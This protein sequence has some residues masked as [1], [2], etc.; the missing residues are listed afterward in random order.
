MEYKIQLEE[1]LK[2][3]YTFVSDIKPSDWTEQNMIMQKPF[4]GVFK[5]SKTPYAVEIINRISNDDSAHTVALMKGAQ[6]GM[7]AGVIIP[8][9]CWIIKNNPGN[10]YLSVGA[11]DLIEKAMEKL[12]LAI[13]CT[14]LRTLIKPQT[15]RA[16]NNKTGDTNSK[17]EFPNGYVSIGSANNHKNLRQVDLQFVFLDD[18]EAVKKSSDQSGDTLSMVKQRQASYYGKSKLFLISTPELKDKSNIEPAY[19]LGDQR[20]FMV[21][22][23]C[24]G[25]FIDLRWAYEDEETKQMVGVYWELNES[26]ELIPESVGY[27]CQEC[28]QFFDDKNKHELLNSGYWKPTAK[29]VSEGYFSYH[30]S[31]LYAPIGMFDWLYYVKEYLLAVP[32]NGQRDEPKYKTFVNVCLGLTYE[33]ETEKLNANKIQRNTRNYEVGT[34]PEKQSITDGNGKIILLTCACDLNG[35]P[36]DARLDYEV[37]AWSESGSTYSI[38]HGSIGTF[39]PNQSAQTKAKDDRIKWT[40]EHNKHNSVWNEFKNVLDNVWLVDTGR[41]MKIFASGVDTGYQEKEAFEFIDGVNLTMFGLKG[42]K[43]DKYLPFTLDAKSF[44]KGNARPNLFLVLGGKIKDDLSKNMNLK[45]DSVNDESQ[46]V[47]FCNFPEPSKGLYTYNNFFSHYE[48]EQRK[49]EMKDGNSVSARWVKISPTAQNHLWDCRV[50][51]VVVRDILMSKV[52]E[53]LKIK[54]GVWQDFVGILIGAKK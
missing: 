27:K 1:I 4:P 26:Q 13:D 8:G 34:I 22:C 35:R 33:M 14:G 39:I 54:N 21:P 41:K 3:G 20:K 10:T 46:P 7:S 24:C 25:T 53:E 43:E 12:D 52:F 23:P 51:N 37:L 36:D 40:Y 38:T 31:A 16:K 17:K 19:M 30:I 50:Y 11:P 32:P 44:K 18:F 28:K 5:Y 2:A 48:S 9:I 47:G 45:W 6:I 42:D 49:I 15:F 29:P